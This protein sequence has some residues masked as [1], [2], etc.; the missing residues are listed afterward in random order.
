[1]YYYFNPGSYC[2]QA[3]K[4]QNTAPRERLA[5]ASVPQQQF[6]ALY[7]PQEALKYGTVF[8]ELNLSYSGRR[9]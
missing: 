3:A 2:P 5:E 1:L 6:R 7:T 4:A 9:W 8:K